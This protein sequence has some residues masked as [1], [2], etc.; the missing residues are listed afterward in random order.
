[1]RRLEA[2][3]LPAWPQAPRQSFPRLCRGP[4]PLGQGQRGCKHL[5][6]PV[7]AGVS[8]EERRRQ[9]RRADGSL[10]SDPPIGVEEADS[11]KRQRTASGAE[12]TDS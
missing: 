5:S 11:Q 3:R 1:M 2:L 7:G 10:V 6:A 9:L 4:P 8:E 12:E